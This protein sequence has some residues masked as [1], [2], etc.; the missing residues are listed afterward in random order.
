[1]CSSDLLA[2]DDAEVWIMLGAV[3]G[4]LGRFPESETCFRTVV[5]LHSEHYAAWDNLG[6][7][8]MYQGKTQQAEASYRRA[9]E[10][11]PDYECAYNNLANL[12]RQAGRHREA[13]AC[14][15]QQAIRIR[16]KHAEAHNNLGNILSFHR[17]ATGLWDFYAL[18]ECRNLLLYS[19]TR[20]SDDRRAR[21][22]STSRWPPHH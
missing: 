13:V 20:R 3:Y 11:K 8:L 15:E 5:A 4:R 9:I 2:P 17:A 14:C 6:I 21:K 16:S 1:M 22:E 19:C 18:S 12:L 7:A 10:V